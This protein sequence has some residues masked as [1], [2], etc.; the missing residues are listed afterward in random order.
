MSVALG[1][2]GSRSHGG[3]RASPTAHVGLWLPIR[4]DPAEHC[5]P[6][7]TTAGAVLVFNRRRPE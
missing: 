7:R 2:E 6:I 1:V 5:T 3:D 4:R